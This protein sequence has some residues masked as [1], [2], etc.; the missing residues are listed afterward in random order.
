MLPLLLHLQ[1]T[2]VAAFAKRM[3]LHLALL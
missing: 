3:H 2:A 1:L